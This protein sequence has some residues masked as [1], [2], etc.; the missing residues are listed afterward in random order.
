MVIPY[1]YKVNSI[2]KN[3]TDLSVTRTVICT[4][5]VFAPYIPYTH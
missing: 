3:I 4:D 5:D 2:K 1:I